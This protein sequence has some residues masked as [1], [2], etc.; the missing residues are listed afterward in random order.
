V[1]KKKE[2]GG[3]EKANNQSTFMTRVT[4][5]ISA[6]SAVSVERAAEGWGAGYGAKGEEGKVAAKREEGTD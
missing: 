2:E 3:G 5:I 1:K 4:S 6:V